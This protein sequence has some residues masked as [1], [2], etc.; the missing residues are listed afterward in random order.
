MWFANI[1][2]RELF[3]Q[4]WFT[5]ELPGAYF[6]V[7]SLK[8]LFGSQYR[9]H[10]HRQQQAGSTVAGIAM[11]IVIIRSYSFCSTSFLSI[12]SSSRWTTCISKQKM[13][14]IVTKRIYGAIPLFIIWNGTYPKY[15]D[16][17]L[18]LCYTCS[19]IDYLYLSRHPSS[20]PLPS[21]FMLNSSL[22]V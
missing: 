6:T 16:Q 21:W 10:N 5:K 4:C 9:L 14:L 11:S 20:K 8:R 15:Y 18:Q 12:V 19:K 17:E 2:W 7:A 3:T 13:D 22:N 1:T